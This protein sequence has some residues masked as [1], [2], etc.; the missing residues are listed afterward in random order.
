MPRQDFFVPYRL[1]SNV[2][3]YHNSQNF[4]IYK[5]IIFIKAEHFL[6]SLFWKTIAR[7]EGWST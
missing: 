7:L 3:Y 6:R 2:K 1:P 4:K 5:Y